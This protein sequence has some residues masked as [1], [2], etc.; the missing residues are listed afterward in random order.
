M[1]SRKEEFQA[2]TS[3]SSHHLL[4]LLLTLIRQPP[5]LVLETYSD[6]AANSAASS[7]IQQWE[8]HQGSCNAPS[9]RVVGAKAALH[10]LSLRLGKMRENRK[11]TLLPTQLL[12]EA[13]PQIST[14]RKKATIIPCPPQAQASL[15][16]A[17]SLQESV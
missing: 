15:P 5:W 13:H 12:T 4:E 7:A 8:L 1:L 3:F 17:R 2:L 9:H 10:H 14:I 16:G 6:P 11:R